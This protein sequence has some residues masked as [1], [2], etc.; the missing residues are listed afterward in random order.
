[1]ENKNNI[2]IE[3]LINFCL[4]ILAVIYLILNIGYSGPAYLHDEIGY[5]AKA[6]FLAGFNVDGA[7]YTFTILLIKHLS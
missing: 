5:L 3:K 4:I 2:R 1:M 7:N 6:S